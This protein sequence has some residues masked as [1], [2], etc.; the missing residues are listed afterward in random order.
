MLQRAIGLVTVEFEIFFHFQ[1]KLSRL[2]NLLV[3]LLSK[4]AFFIWWDDLCNATNNS[5]QFIFAV[6][7]VRS[8]CISIFIN[9]FYIERI[10]IG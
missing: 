5:C 1:L 10:S 2:K 4:F 9:Y 6:V 7:N 3:F 8:V